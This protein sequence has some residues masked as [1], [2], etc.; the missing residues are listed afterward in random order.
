MPSQSDSSNRAKYAVLAAAT[1]V[2]IQA[3][4]TTAGAQVVSQ[5]PRQNLPSDTRMPR[6]IKP[7][8]GTGGTTRMIGMMAGAPVYADS[9]GAYFTVDNA[10]GQPVQVSAEQVARTTCCILKYPGRTS[11]DSSAVAS[12]RKSSGR[13]IIKFGKED[14]RKVEIVGVDADGRVLHRNNRGEIFHV[15]PATGDFIFVKP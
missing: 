4:P 9:A 3:V 12:Q 5:P 10:T 13:H 15:D 2:A 6:A 7:F 14:I 11:A 1:M 8:S